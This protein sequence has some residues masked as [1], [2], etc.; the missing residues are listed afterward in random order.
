MNSSS[1]ESRCAKFLAAGV[2]NGRYAPS[3]PYLLTSVSQMCVWLATVLWLATARRVSLLSQ[4]RPNVRACFASF[5]PLPMYYPFICL[6]GA[7]FLAATVVWAWPGQIDAT[8]TSTQSWNHVVWRALLVAKTFFGEFVVALVLT[9]LARRSAGRDD[10]LVA[11]RVALLSAAIMSTGKFF[12]Y[13]SAFGLGHAFPHVE[14]T[15]VS[16]WQLR[17]GG[18]PALECAG[19]WVLMTYNALLVVV[20]AGVIATYVCRRLGCRC[21]PAPGTAAATA[22]RLPTHVRG[23][24][25]VDHVEHVEAHRTMLS[26]SAISAGASRSTS[27]LEIS[28]ILGHSRPSAPSGEY[29]AV[30]SLH[31]TQSSVVLLAANAEHRGVRCCPTP[32]LARCCGRVE[33]TWSPRASSLGF[34]AVLVVCRVC[35]IISM[36]GDCAQVADLIVWAVLYPVS[37]LL[38][39]HQDSNLWR[40]LGHAA[41]EEGKRRI[42]EKRGGGVEQLV[43]AL[44]RLFSPLSGG[45]AQTPLL[46]SIAGDLDERVL[47]V[48]FTRI[49]LKNVLAP[50]NAATGSNCVRRGRMLID[51]DRGSEYVDVAVKIVRCRHL[52][53]SSAIDILCELSALGELRQYR[54]P[55]I[56]KLLGVSVA[57][58]ELWMLVEYCGR[59][60]LYQ[61]I[62]SFPSPDPCAAWERRLDMATQVSERECRRERERARARERGRARV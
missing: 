53:Q 38:A 20:C 39:L 55:N 47:V 41:Q 15:C 8:T 50:A 25:N 19:E 51:G 1:F 42:V 24:S 59:G 31:R 32:L 37:V 7:T 61:I 57:P 36:F 14:V 27:S 22:A 17:R 35:D 46:N 11:R 48:D 28:S 58:P 29:G 40:A 21:A 12:S 13:A 6:L 3:L 10:L 18:K 43:T 54:H 23:A 44:P 4:T 30:A 56:V 49:E 2:V 52:T 9:F 45:F 5:V 62:H 26:G 34:A 16:E 60:S 33:A